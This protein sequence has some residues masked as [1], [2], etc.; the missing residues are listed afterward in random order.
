M[1]T[2]GLGFRDRATG[3]PVKQ[4]V[5]WPHFNFPS[6]SSRPKYLVRVRAKHRLSVSRLR[7]HTDIPIPHVK[8]WGPFVDNPLGVG[9]LSLLN[10]SK[11]SNL[12]LR[13]VSARSRPNSMI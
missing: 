5:Q 1:S 3:F 4:S 8:A 12:R 10:S 6:G 7:Q 9:P 13:F 2:A 11:G